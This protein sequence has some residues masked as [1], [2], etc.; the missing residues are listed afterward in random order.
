MLVDKSK[1]IRFIPVVIACLGIALL[2][3]LYF[4]DTSAYS[5]HITALI[6]C[7]VIAPAVQGLIDFIDKSDLKLIV[8]DVL[9]ILASLLVLFAGEYIALNIFDLPVVKYLYYPGTM[10][11]S[12]TS[13]IATIYVIIAFYFSRTSNVK[14]K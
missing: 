11:D 6:L 2:F 14:T 3:Y 1:Y 8:G 5:H 7:G 9:L 10:F 4:I 13:I 12:V